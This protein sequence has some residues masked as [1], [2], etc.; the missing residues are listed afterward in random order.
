MFNLAEAS[1]KPMYCG[2]IPYNPH[3][4]ENPLL[5]MTTEVLHFEAAAAIVPALEKGLWTELDVKH[6]AP[7]QRAFQHFANLGKRTKLHRFYGLMG[8]RSRAVQGQ[9]VEVLAWLVATK[10]LG[11]L[12]EAETLAWLLEAEVL[13]RLAAALVWLVAA[14]AA[15]PLGQLLQAEALSWLLP[16]DLLPQPAEP[17]VLAQLEKAATETLGWPL[18]IE[19]ETLAQPAAAALA[20]QRR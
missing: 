3:V 14:A 19:T 6:D 7:P 4:R 10:S 17:E 16:L 2:P 9:L 8:K 13:G 20:Q 15:E 11:R 1:D 18:A 12:P 5:R